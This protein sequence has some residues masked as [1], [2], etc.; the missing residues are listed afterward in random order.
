MLI[1]AGTTEATELA[2]VLHMSG[3]DVI[4]SLA[5]VTADPVP[6][7]GRLRRGGFGGVDGLRRYLDAENIAAV[8]DATHPF[9]AQ[10]PFHAAVAC[11][12]ARVS[13]CRLL[14]DP[15][16]RR[17]TD[18]WLEVDDLAAGAAALAALGARRVLL[19]TGRQSIGPFVGCS[20]QWFLTRSIES[21]SVDVANM[22]S[23]RDR[24]PFTVAGERAL[25]IE[26]RID[27]LVTKNSGGVA[28]EAKLAAARELGVTVVMVRRPAQPAGVHTV[29]TVHE[30]SEWVLLRRASTVTHER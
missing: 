22:T 1:L 24:G 6:R 15:W 28:T 29:S 12:Q 30:A 14:R 7:P 25:M 9:A 19:A 3:I 13:L 17:D 23:I 18:R 4:S 11:E 26:H 16:H 21:P 10:M 27:T 20:D 2:A 5:G 8:V